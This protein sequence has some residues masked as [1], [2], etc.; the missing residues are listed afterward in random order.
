[1]KN[2]TLKKGHSLLGSIKTNVGNNMEKNSTLI[3]ICNRT[4]GPI[5]GFFFKTPFYGAQTTLYCALE[6]SL[7]R[8]TGNYYA[9]CER[10]APDRAALDEEGQERLWRLSN[11]MVGL[12]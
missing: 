12:E 2:R 5:L 7:D 6:E 1:M 8:D 11:K 4:I 9:N 10:T 3:W